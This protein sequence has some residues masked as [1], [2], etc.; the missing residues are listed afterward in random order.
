MKIRI[1]TNQKV[2]DEIRAKIKEADGHCPCQLERTQDTKCMCKDFR[3]K[4][5]NGETGWCHCG[6]YYAEE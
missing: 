2:V 3:T 4:V 6:L 1:N 5:D